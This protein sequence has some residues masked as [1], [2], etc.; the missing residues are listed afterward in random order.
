M[1]CEE[2]LQEIY[3]TYFRDEL[4]KNLTIGETF[5][6]IHSAIREVYAP[7]EPTAPEP[8]PIYDSLRALFQDQ[9]KLT[10]VSLAAVVREAVN[11]SKASN[12]HIA[13]LMKKMAGQSIEKSV[14]NPAM[15]KN[16]E[17]VIRYRNAASHKTR[18]PVG[19]YEAS[20]AIYCCVA[21]LLW[22]RRE[23]DNTNW[24]N[25]QATILDAAVLRNSPDVDL[26]DLQ[27]RKS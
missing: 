9:T 12:K 16:V 18:V 19:E 25:S 20:R 2:Y 8:Q 21:L 23:I 1:I 24:D 11:Y 10:A 4:P 26:T 3:E 15:R 7:Q 14:F 27:R 17:E 13:F 6:L 22:W 5:D